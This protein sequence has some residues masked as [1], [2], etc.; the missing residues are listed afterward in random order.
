MVQEYKKIGVVLVN[1]NKS[2]CDTVECV[3]FLINS[4]CMQ[5]QIYIVDNDSEQEY[6]DLLKKNIPRNIKISFNSE[7]SGFAK[8]CNM[9]IKYFLA[10]E[11][12]YYILL[13]N[14]DTVVP[15]NFLKD[16]TAPFLGPDPT[17]GIVA[18]LIYY[19]D[20]KD[21]LW[22]GGGDFKPLYGS[23]VH[24][25]DKS[26]IPM[27]SYVITNFATG[28]C[29]LLRKNIIEEV[30]FLDEDYF[31]YS[32]DVDFC[33]RLQRLGYKIILNTKT[34]IFHKL[35]RSIEGTS[36]EKIIYMNESHKL[37]IRKN[38]I[39]AKRLYYIL[40]FYLGHSH[41]GINFFLRG[42]FGKSSVVFKSLVRSILIDFNQS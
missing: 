36:L 21:E 26:K 24:N 32:E 29:M 7:N 33:F 41:G 18:P 8:G 17:I 30:G 19:Y 34:F 2:T 23:Y 15:A 16:L 25:T 28:C 31:M 38:F 10:R 4:G 9:G 27:H 42:Q 1:Y 22:Y 37:F 14:N 3:N 12:I 20:N 6:K 35:G 11:D 40:M 5:E 39:G 13:L